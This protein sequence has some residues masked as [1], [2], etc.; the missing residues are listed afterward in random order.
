MAAR[1]ARAARRRAEVD[2]L[3]D[4]LAIADFTA[5]HG[6][7]ELE[8]VVVTIPA[9]GEA[10][11]IE[12]VL[13]ELPAEVCGLGVSV[14]V[15]VDGHHPAEEEGL[16]ARRV[17]AAGHHVCVAPINRG[18]GAALR[19]AY[20]L[21]RD[22]GARYIVGIDA[23]GQY[24][25]AEMARLVGPLVGGEADFVTGSRRLGRA[26]TDDRVR[27]AGVYVFARVISALTGC[28]ITDPANGFRA[29]TADV[30]A[31]VSLTEEQ[32][33]ASELL[34]GAIQRGYRV[35]ERPTTMRKRTSGTSRKEHNVVYGL[36]FAR[37][38]AKTALRGLRERR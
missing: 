9:Y 10:E 25:P 31:D 4:D 30:T 28:E 16:T 8:P 22:G 38:I 19:L 24:V 27:G 23:D 34:V 37:V 7:P 26:E 21:A 17:T 20:R 6:S 12:D 1:G 36:Q 33:Q 18:Q 2:R 13:A 11:S 5:R 15:V 32:Y 35:V 3:V 14:L 29:M